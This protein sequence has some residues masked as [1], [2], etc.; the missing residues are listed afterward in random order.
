MIYARYYLYRDIVPGLS[1]RCNRASP[2][3]RC[4]TVLRPQLES[5]YQLETV[6]HSVSEKIAIRVMK[7][8]GCVS[9]AAVTSLL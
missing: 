8:G 4:H 9:C 6:W 1:Y 5:C 2:S 7:L 3:A